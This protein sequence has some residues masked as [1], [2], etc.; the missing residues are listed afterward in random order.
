MDPTLSDPTEPAVARPAEPLAG[1][2]VAAHTEAGPAAARTEAGA[3]VP[4]PPK[5]R[6]VGT[7]PA[8]RAVGAAL[9]F[10]AAAALAGVAP[11]DRGVQY[12]AFGIVE[13]VFSLLL[14]YILLQRRAWTSPAGVAGWAAVVYGT[15]ATAQIAEFLF[16]PPGV[17]E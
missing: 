6:R 2:A 8:Q 12:R 11:T 4:A 1:T 3:V 15:L 9:L 10:L 5:P 13:G 7:T 17:V 14:T 16:P